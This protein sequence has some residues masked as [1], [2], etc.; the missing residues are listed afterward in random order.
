MRKLMGSA[1]QQTTAKTKNSQEMAS[2]GPYLSNR[3]P[4]TQSSHSAVSSTPF[5]HQTTEAD[6]STLLRIQGILVDLAARNDSA[7]PNPALAALFEQSKIFILEAE[8]RAEVREQRLVKMLEQ[9]S[10]P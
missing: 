6:P 3:E 2:R 10:D 8:Q 4:A 1:T 9:V 5:A 7:K